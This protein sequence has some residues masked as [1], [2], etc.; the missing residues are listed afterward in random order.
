MTKPVWPRKRRV[1]STL[2]FGYHIST[3]VY[4][5]LWFPPTR[6]QMMKH[7]ST[8][9]RQTHACVS[10]WDL[11]PG[12]QKRGQSNPYLTCCV[13]VAI[14]N[15]RRLSTYL[16]HTAQPPAFFLLQTPSPTPYLVVTAV[17]QYLYQGTRLLTVQCPP[18]TCRRSVSCFWL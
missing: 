7:N 12:L 13:F 6:H 17:K 3:S 2:Y 14:Q 9:T 8:D 16:C 4:S 15:N 5:L 1:S 11:L 10:C 18:S